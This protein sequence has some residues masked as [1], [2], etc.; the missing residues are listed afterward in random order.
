MSFCALRRRAW[1]LLLTSLV[2][3]SAESLITAIC[4][5]TISGMGMRPL[6]QLHMLGSYSFTCR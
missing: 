1:G 2:L 4:I 6:R 5:R 3:L